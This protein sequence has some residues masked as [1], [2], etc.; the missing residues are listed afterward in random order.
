ML[1]LFDFTVIWTPFTGTPFSST[2]VPRNSTAAVALAT[3]NANIK[4]AKWAAAGQ[5]SGMKTL[6]ALTDNGPRCRAH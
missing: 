5:L 3:P 1:P 4:M 2:T 6:P